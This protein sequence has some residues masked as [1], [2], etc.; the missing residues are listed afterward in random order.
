MTSLILIHRELGKMSNIEEQVKNIDRSEYLL[1]GFCEMGLFERSYLLLGMEEALVSYLTEPELMSDLLSALADY[2]IEFI[3]KFDEVVNLDIVWYGDDWGT[4]S[5]LFIPE[6]SWRA[7]IKPHTTRIY[8]RM[9]DR[10]II[11]NQHSCGKIEKI[12]GDV[13]EMGADIWNLCQPCNDLKS[14]KEQYGDSIAFHGGID[15]QFVL[16]RPGAT[17]EEIITEVRKRISEMAEGGGYIAGPS[18]TIPSHRPDLVR[19]FNE[20]IEKFG[21][22]Y[23]KPH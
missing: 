10:E 18:H 13:V 2:K 11:I 5:D 7:I 23:Y 15:S 9:K 8:D 22:E 1:E 20:E 6:A 3:T 19:A 16:N 21:K 4:Q 12:F 17:R 14:M